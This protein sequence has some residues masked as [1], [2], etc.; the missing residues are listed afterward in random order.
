MGS[1]THSIQQANRK[2]DKS[3]NTHRKEQP[4][5][6]DPRSRSPNSAKEDDEPKT[7]DNFVQKNIDRL[8][9]MKAKRAQEIK[10]MEE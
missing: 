6:T 9:A 8:D 5:R 4:M 7:Q 3:P 10:M 2:Q 1:Y